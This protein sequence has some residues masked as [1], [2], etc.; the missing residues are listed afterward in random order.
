METILYLDILK[1][2]FDKLDILS[3]INLRATNHF[4]HSNFKSLTFTKNQFEELKI[5]FHRLYLGHQLKKPLIDWVLNGDGSFEVFTQDKEDIFS[6]FFDLQE[7]NFNEDEYKSL[8]DL[9]PFLTKPLKYFSYHKQIHSFPPTFDQITSNLP[10]LYN[11]IT[12]IFNELAKT[13]IKDSFLVK[14]VSQMY[15]KNCTSEQWNRQKLEFFNQ[16]IHNPSTLKYND[17]IHLYYST[18]VF[19]SN[20]DKLGNLLFDS[21]ISEYHSLIGQNQSLIQP[22]SKEFIHLL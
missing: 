21:W 2:I 6:L 3:Q 12:E 4:F 1:I 7:N 9:Q 16:F 13:Q 14:F 17:T 8:S 5:L 20:L 19:N 11:N 22:H 10:P 15:Y 18:P